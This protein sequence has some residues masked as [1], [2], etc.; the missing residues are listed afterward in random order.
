MTLPLNYYK[1][2]TAG[3]YIYVC[4]QRQSLAVHRNVPGCTEGAIKHTSGR[5]LTKGACIE[6]RSSSENR[7]SKNGRS[8][9]TCTGERQCAG[10]WKNR[11]TCQLSPNNNLN[12]ACSHEEQRVRNLIEIF[13]F[14]HITKNIFAIPRRLE[15]L[16]VWQKLG[17]TSKS[18][19]EQF[20]K[21]TSPKMKMG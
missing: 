1:D 14:N 21:Q 8:T 16:D 3:N 2:W 9:S 17:Q 6:I 7:T 13:T 19:T 4:H 18:T 12:T 10:T 15:K 5:W 11:Y 20:Q